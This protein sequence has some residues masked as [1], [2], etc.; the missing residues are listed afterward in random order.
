MSKSARNAYKT[1]SP[2]KPIRMGWNIY[3]LCDQGEVSDGFCLDAVVSVGDYTYDQVLNGSKR[4][5][6]LYR[7][8]H[9]RDH[10]TTCSG[11]SAFYCP[12]A[13]HVAKKV[14]QKKKRLV[15]TVSCTFFVNCVLIDILILCF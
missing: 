4:F 3:R 13:M 9:D 6:L 14:W 8:L 2:N 5:T 7:F 15:F 12:R 10:G 1:R 11:D